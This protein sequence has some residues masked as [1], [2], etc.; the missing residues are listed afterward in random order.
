MNICIFDVIFAVRAISGGEDEKLI[1]W[2]Q[3]EVASVEKF[4]AK[5]EINTDLRTDQ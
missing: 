4:V 3:V 1:S 2:D 5:C